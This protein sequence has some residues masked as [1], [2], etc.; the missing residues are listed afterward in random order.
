MAKGNSAVSKHYWRPQYT[1]DLNEIEQCFGTSVL[2]PDNE[3][4]A[5]TEKRQI[6]LSS[7]LSNEVKTA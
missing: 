7:I 2:L 4:I 5:S 6:P 3:T 1:K